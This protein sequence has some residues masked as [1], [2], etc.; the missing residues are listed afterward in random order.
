MNTLYSAAS[1]AVT[2]ALGGGSA[3]GSS[4]QIEQGWGLVDGRREVEQ[5]E[6]VARQY[7]VP[8]TPAQTERQRRYADEVQRTSEIWGAHAT[9]QSYEML[10]EGETDPEKLIDG[11]IARVSDT[12]LARIGRDLVAMRY[13][14][15]KSSNW[16]KVVALCAIYTK[17]S[18]SIYLEQSFYKELRGRVV[19][20]RIGGE[21]LLGAVRYC[22]EFSANS[23]DK[24]HGLKVLDAG[25][26]LVN[27]R[28]W[29]DGET[30]L[31]AYMILLDRYVE[32]DKGEESHNIFT[33]VSSLAGSDSEI[34][35]QA[36]ICMMRLCIQRKNGD[37]LR[38][39]FRCVENVTGI[40]EK[41]TYSYALYEMVRGLLSSGQCREAIGFLE[42]I[43][44]GVS[45]L[46]LQCCR[47][48]AFAYIKS[49]EE[50]KALEWY[51]RLPIEGELFNVAW[52]GDLRFFIKKGQEM[53]VEYIL[54][55]VPEAEL[56]APLLRAFVTL[57]LNRR[58]RA[59]DEKGIE[60]YCRLCKLDSY[61]EEDTFVGEFR[62][63]FQEML[64]LG[65]V[66]LAEQ[67]VMVLAKTKVLY[68]ESCFKMMFEELEK[69]THN[70]KT[71][72]GWVKLVAEAPEAR[73]AFTE[74][75][76]MKLVGSTPRRVT[77]FKLLT[78][79]RGEVNDEGGGAS[80]GGE[81]KKQTNGDI[82]KANSKVIGEALS[83]YATKYHKKTSSDLD[84]GEE[85][86]SGSSE[87]DDDSQ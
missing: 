62:Q 30:K 77:T 63:I 66:D 25:Y 61:Q 20:K 45:D 12:K 9:E 42:E 59:S 47:W 58:N 52:K 17:N 83:S 43:D 79:L 68:V 75:G 27:W 4:G 21:E 74:G 33:A 86:S 87:G 14:L 69:E 29:E 23:R 37:A 19:E 15:E 78:I 3:S 64:D 56:D 51:K 82:L 44:K 18:V 2:Y 46:Y 54:G 60:R 76:F 13:I 72:A 34:Y 39:Y 53:L 81:K 41:G 48:M 22:S 55:I 8:K 71:A 1:G 73:E 28:H 84:A 32:L 31:K 36:C 65:N 26:F 57:L 16:G 24:D 6:G 40:K 10:C 11:L 80:S 67:M 49:K 70:L 85:F 50:R 35:A 5:G 38:Q 7:G